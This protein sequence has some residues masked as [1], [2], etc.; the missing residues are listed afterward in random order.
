MF[1]RTNKLKEI[2]P[3]VP[4]IFIVYTDVYYEKNN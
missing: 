2:L 1:D 4:F 3:A